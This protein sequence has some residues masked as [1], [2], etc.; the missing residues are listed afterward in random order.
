MKHWKMA[1]LIFVL[2]FGAYIARGV[3]EYP[4]RMLNGRLAY[5]EI[6]TTKDRTASKRRVKKRR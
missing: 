1:S 3:E 4:L 5:G 6:A 2:V